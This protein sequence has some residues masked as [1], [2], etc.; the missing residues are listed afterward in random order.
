MADVGD[1][2][3]MPDGHHAKVLVLRESTM[4]VEYDDGFRDTIPRPESEYFCKTCNTTV[5]VGEEHLHGCPVEG[6]TCGSRRCN[7]LGSCQA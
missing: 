3:E 1:V 7:E 6:D 2:L 5:K 4:Q